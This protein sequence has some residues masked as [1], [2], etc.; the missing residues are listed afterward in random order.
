MF[1]IY[2]KMLVLIVGRSG[3]WKIML[4][5]MELYRNVSYQFIFYFCDVFS[6]LWQPPFL[7]ILAINNYYR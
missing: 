5:Y 2:P 1:I 6:R 7:R 3:C 4:I